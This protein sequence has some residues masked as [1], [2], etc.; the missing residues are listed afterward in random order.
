L[1]DQTVAVLAEK[2]SVA[3]DIAR[4]LG[5][6]TRGDGYLHGNG[7]VVTWA[8][9]HL[10]ALA[11][12]HEIHAEWKAWRRD[13]L[14]MLPE[15]WPLVVYD[16]TKDQFETVRKILSSP[17]V[18]RVICATDAGREGELIFRYIYEAAGC[19][20]PANRLWISSLT[21]DAIRKGFDALKPSEEYD[22]LADA[23][24]GRSRADWLVGMNLS[25]AYAL[26]YGGDLSV[27]RVQT[28]TL[29]MLVEREL[30]IRA[31][32]PED[33]FEVIATFRPS[34]RPDAQ[35]YQG[36]WFRDANDP[37]KSMRLPATGPEGG[38]EAAQIVER[39]RTGKASIELIQAETQ[40][41]AAPFLYDLTELQRHANRL[42]GFSAQKTLDLA[43]ALYERHK[44][45]SYPRTDS[46]HLSKDVAATLPGIVQ[47]IAKPYRELMAAGTGERALGRR[48]VEDSKV[49]DHH[50]IIPTTVSSAGADLSTDERRIYDLVCRRLLSAWHED[51]IWSVTTVITA[52]VNGTFT[53][54]Y[55]SSGTAVQQVGWKVLDFRPE[56]RRAPGEE[57]EQSLP[58]G[59]ARG[60]AQDVLE[61]EA[62]RKKTRA[63]KRFT[64]ATLLTAMETA[65]KT[66]DE[67]ELSDAM[68]ENG[69]GTPATRAGI[70]ETLLKREYVERQGKNLGATD[71]GIHLI[72][73]VHPEVKSPA[74]TGQ[75]EAF[76]KKI[77]RGEAQLE[78]F[79][80]G[81]EN[82]VRDVVGKV[83]NGDDAAPAARAT[84]TSAGTPAAVKSFEFE[85][86]PDLLHKAFGFEAFRSNQE[87]VCRTVIE[88]RDA[89]LVMPTGAGKSLCYQL[90]G[91]ARGGTTLV[92]SPLIALMEDQYAKLRALG[93]AVECIHSGRTREAS[94]KV[95]VDY[96]N[97][98]LQFLFV[99]PE[100][101]RV[102]GF[103]EMLARRKPSLVA[104]DEAHCISQWGHDF[105]P[106]YR[107]LGQYVPTLR[108]APVIAL[109]ATA[110]VTVQHD[111]RTQLGLDEPASFIHG[112][113][114]E[115]I[116]IEAVEIAPGQRA[117]LA[118]SLLLEEERRPAI[119]Y[120]P[121]RK[122]AE[123]VAEML[124]ERFPAAAYHAGL[125]AERRKR[126]Q[127]N[128]LSGKT[129]VVVATIAFGMGIDKPNVRTVVHTALPGS[130]EAYYQ[131]VGRAGRDGA[132]SRAI[133]MHSYADRHTHDFFFE[134]DYPDVA[135]LDRIFGLLSAAP[136]ER[137]ALWKRSR[138]PQEVFE[139]AL[140][141]LWAHG[142]AVADSSDNVT[143][144]SREWRDSYI[145]QGEQK[146]AQ[147]E[148]VIRY[149]QSNECRMASLVRHFGD[150]ADGRKNC[151]ICDFCAPS[152]C[153]AQQYRQ[154]TDAE[155]RLT[156]DIL[157]ELEGAPR[158]VGKLHSQL[159]AKGE[160]SRDDFEE[161][162]GS[163][164]RAGLVRLTE[165]VFE[166][167]GK[168][169]PYRKAWLARDANFVSREAP[170]EFTVRRMGTAVEKPA[171]KGRARKK[172]RKKE[173]IPLSRPAGRAKAKVAAPV[174]SPIEAGSRESKAEEL[175]RAWR[176]A[177]AKRLGVPAFRIMTDKVL[178][179]IAK[180][181][182]KTA[183]ELLAIPGIGINAVE[184]YGAQIYRVLNEATR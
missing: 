5:A 107:L 89:L 96:L 147:I 23:A 31:F 72:E 139:K 146:R 44:L 94:R 64:E 8:I 150:V 87:E 26:A 84:L 33:Y 162:V 20:K 144:G 175:L 68:K 22:P 149:S 21:P 1:A 180:R 25:R 138:I 148:R 177:Q 181:N 172:A 156:F 47:T 38:V 109:T 37:H 130:L 29:A 108:P 118:L 123:S 173:R 19:S 77:E 154:P 24:R 82:Y 182:P 50:A 35:S 83:G 163:L 132:P 80:R 183:A 52:I 60:Q 88:G 100:R 169:I 81:I 166:K 42:F 92:I 54:R 63:P 86:L 10:A 116:A 113:R 101:L 40:R 127:E 27:G 53:D 75:W 58:A 164:A 36:T 18:S 32:V 79:L 73:V 69:L 13:L 131:E 56:W 128:F 61:A 122:Q 43:Q 48:F 158:S 71:K 65:G 145:A 34:G 114:R 62:V 135:M 124:A 184:K 151:G 110:T 106:D 99:A 9:G 67:K 15:S 74:M 126:V 66:L 111:I 41:M 55:H 90:P 167:D 105:R 121:S 16:K 76:L 152:A 143:A 95:C 3:H 134:R 12:P 160:A 171:R 141:K 17:K 157:D 125:D 102:P 142:G 30:A 14:P 161:L 46:R 11:Q 98:R 136:I 4:V 119:V 28:P 45:L 117:A 176:L 120:T 129:E 103:P 153:I 2:P 174:E 170:P 133:L 57:Q 91:I 115:N 93:F 59:L 104:I 155:M 159:C 70:I 7:Y 165:E 97:G 168:S 6:N 178:E 137:A 39:A 179:A 49:R 140:E 85:S 78:P 51:H 112:F